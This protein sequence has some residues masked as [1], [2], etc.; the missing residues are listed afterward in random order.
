M[1]FIVFNT[2]AQA[3]NYEER[4]GWK[5]NFHDCRCCGTEEYYSVDEK[6]RLV[7]K[8]VAVHDKG[9]V[10]F[11]TTVIGRFKKGA[12]VDRL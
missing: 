1:G 5:N 3:K 10:T 11:N 6:T 7:L 9:R 8:I 12:K 2:L 4:Q